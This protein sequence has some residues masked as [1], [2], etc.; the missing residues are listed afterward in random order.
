MIDE[1]F[2]TFERDG[3]VEWN[4][5]FAEPVPVRV[6]THMLGLP[7]ADIPR[8]KQWSAAWILPF[9][10]PLR[11]NEDVWVAEQVVEIYEYLAA[12]I[13]AKRDQPGDDMITHLTRNRVRG[14]ATAHRSGDHHDR[15]PPVHRR[16][17]D[18]H[19]RH[20][21]GALDHAARRRARYGQLLADRSLM[22]AFVEEVLRLESPTQGLWR[23]V[24]EDTELHGVRTARRLDGA[25]PL[26]ER[27][28]RRAHVRVPAPGAT[29]PPELAPPPRVHAR[30]APVPGRRPQ[31]SR[32]GAHARARARPAAEVRA[33]RGQNDFA[34]VPMFTMRALRELH[35]EFDV[36]QR[37]R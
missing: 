21:V 11:Q 14:G 5:Q 1:Q 12:A 34:H 2:A 7:Q 25:P 4:R 9:V 29:R 18:H 37:A 17:R 19:V 33:R 36:P 35:L 16:Q 20:D 31:P 24:A 28:P 10:R 23:D 6:I 22:P 3:R 30:R 26:R 8:L 13:A 15:R 27:Q 32:T